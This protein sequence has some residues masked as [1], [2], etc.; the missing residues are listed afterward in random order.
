[1]FLVFAYLYCKTRKFHLQLILA[2]FA[3]EANLWKLN[4]AKITFY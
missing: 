3:D 4:A 1:M 2:I